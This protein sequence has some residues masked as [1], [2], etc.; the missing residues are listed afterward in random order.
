M[1]VIQ[2]NP[3]TTYWYL[4]LVFSIL[5]VGIGMTGYL[6]YVGEKKQLE[7][8]KGGELAAI[9][10]LKV[11]EISHWRHERLADGW[12]ISQ[13]PFVYS[14]V[15]QWLDNRSDSEL[16][17]EILS[18][19]GSLSQLRDYGSVL[20]YDQEGLLR[21]AVPDRT[22]SAGGDLQRQVLEVL[23]TKQVM[24][25]DL[26]HDKTT[27]RIQLNLFVP[28]SGS[29]DRPAGILAFRI[30]TSK[31]FSPLLETWPIPS[32]TAET[33]LVRR[34]G[35]D[36]VFLHGPRHSKGTALVHRFPIGSERR[37][38]AFA[39]RGGE[40]VMDGIDCGGV[41]VLAAMRPVPDCPWHIIAKVDKAE[42]F[43][44]MHERARLTILLSGIVILATGISVVF[45][46][47]HQKMQFALRQTQAQLQAEAEL[48]QLR[49]Q[50]EL[51]LTSA[52]DGI[53]GLD[54]EGNHTFVN[55]AAAEMLGYNGEEL[56]GKHSHSI[57]H[58]SRNDGTPYAEEDCPIY[59][60]YR[61]GSVHHVDGE[62]FWRKDGTCFPV[63]YISTPIVEDGNLTGAVL[64]FRDITERK[65]T[66]EALRESEE[67]YSTLV[68]RA[69][70][71]V[72][73]VQGE[74]DT[75]VF[76]NEAFAEMHG[77][78]VEEIVGRSLYDFVAAESRVERRHLHGLRLRGEPTS[79]HEIRILCKDGRVKDAET[80]GGLIQY[81][82]KPAVMGI[83]RDV[84]ERKRAQEALIQAHALAER[85]TVELEVA[86]KE[87]ETFSYSVSHD[88]RAPLRSID[89]FSRALLEDYGDALDETGKDYL[90]RVCAASTKMGELIDA[91][92]SLSRLTRTE[93]DRRTV[94][95]AAIAAEIAGELRKTA[96]ERRV[97]FVIPDNVTAWA[98]PAMIRVALDNLLRNAW[99]F[100][101]GHSAARIEFGTY[102]R[103]AEAVYFVRDDGAGFDMA[104]TEKLFTAFQR[105][106]RDN[107]FPGI[108]IGLATV[109]RIIHRHGGRIW[110]EGERDKGATFHFTLEDH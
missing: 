19:M 75:L 67:K 22:D 90:Y 4:L 12:A 101:S 17:T 38:A 39:A 5:T 57:C 105:L 50:N 24:L 58:H 7:Q 110:A 78:L 59:R 23:P 48:A 15:R 63:E 77:Y 35:D 52:G 80:S 44:P 20:L 79:T 94:D 18:W 56:L 42:I 99:K 9:A 102:A 13:N 49:L 34:E 1:S 6:Y 88:L 69:Q 41:P 87:I 14:N 30:D 71:G 8:N 86:N 74:D 43:L 73:I 96:P 85:R 82:G 31:Y 72:Y 25:S 97:E 60:A 81:Q 83:L 91:M 98:D 37:P 53:F 54:L 89:G 104:Y 32:H 62:Y 84:T 109:Q 92:L 64:T 47:R 106:H 2:R 61:V 11:A 40:G 21:A 16:E 95:L 28:L 51:I 29:G 93:P 107:E 100:T 55:R 45:F 70:D 36:V 33:V 3:P 76:V 27:G 108:G 46:W 66:E 10:G 68:E 26:A 103:G 65:Q